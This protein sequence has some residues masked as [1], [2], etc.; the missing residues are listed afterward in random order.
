MNI[1][2][3]HR[4]Q[5][6]GAEGVHIGQ[7]VKNLRSLGHVVDVIS[8][9]DSDPL[10]TAGNNPFDQKSG[11]KARFF[12]RLSMLLPQFLFELLELIY[13]FIAAKKMKAIVDSKSIDLIYERSAF[14]MYAGARLAREKNIAYVVEVNEVAGE[15]RVRKQFFVNQAIKIEQE[16]FQQADAIIVVSSFLK[17]KI[18]K[19]G[20]DGEKIQVVPNAA[21]PSVFA[22][23]NCIRDIRAEIG[24]Q[25]E[26]VIIGFIGWFVA[27]HNFEL[28]IKSL[29]SLKELNVSLMLVGDGPLKEEILSTAKKWGVDG[30]I[31]FSGAAKYINIP[32]YV[33]AMDI[34]VIPGSN[35]YRSPIK[36]FEYMIMGRPV[37]APRLEPIEYI[38]QD[39]EHALL[40]ESDDLESLI[41]VLSTLVSDT[42]RRER[43]GAA[44]RKLVLERHLW[45]HNAQK[46]IDIYNRF[47]V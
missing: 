18:E 39:D 26:T 16:V 7:I 31:I 1:L 36:L 29:R 43:I 33:N 28:L 38:V 4:T 8:P 34:C 14:F 45:A 17:E 24:I 35:A 32:E 40:F 22:P 44:A 13:N 5:G 21:D 23:E 15:D 19:L 25:S 3:H 30:N 42:S 12:D 9:S 11:F 27:W 20:I 47:C 41:R 2:Y 46:I 6:T 10:Q 37:I